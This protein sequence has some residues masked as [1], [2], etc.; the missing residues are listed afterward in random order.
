MTIPLPPSNDTSKDTAQPPKGVQWD[1]PLVDEYLY[2]LLVPTLQRVLCTAT[3]KSTAP[4]SPRFL[5]A[6]LSAC[7]LYVTRGRTPAVQALRWR[8]VEIQPSLQQ[9]QQSPSSSSRRPTIPSTPSKQ[10]IL[11]YI[12]CSVVLPTLYQQLKDWYHEHLVHDA[13][14]SPDSTNNHSSSLQELARQ[15]QRQLFHFLLTWSH[16]VIALAQLLVWLSTFHHP[17]LLAMSLVGFQYAPAPPS[18]SMSSTQQ[19]DE[20][21]FAFHVAYGHRR[22]LYEELLRFGTLVAPVAS[23]QEG[24]D[25]VT[26]YGT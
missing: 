14:P 3:G 2:S 8:V 4:L 7:T 5:V 10:S 26:W 23:W 25:L 15:R 22:W 19:E 13:H 1:V 18:S 6:L 16:K 11:L 24:Q 9:S 20:E 21:R 12:L 17:P